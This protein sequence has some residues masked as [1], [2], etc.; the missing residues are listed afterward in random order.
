MIYGISRQ[1]KKF[2]LA[3][4]TTL[5]RLLLQTNLKFLDVDLEVVFGCA[6]LIDSFQEPLN[7]SL[8]I[9]SRVLPLVSVPNI[10]TLAEPMKCISANIVKAA[11]KPP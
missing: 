3:D 5:V 11:A 8:E 7:H 2:Q 9:S 6:F 10:I 4:P 1:T